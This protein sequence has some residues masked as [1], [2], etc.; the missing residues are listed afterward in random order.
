MFGGSSHVMVF[1]KKA[2]LVWRENA[3]YSFNKDTEEFDSI[4]QNLHSYLAHIVEWSCMWE[5]IRKID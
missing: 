4:K 3:F 5:K 1:E 2:K